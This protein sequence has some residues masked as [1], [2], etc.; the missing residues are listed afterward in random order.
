MDT[1]EAM[2]SASGKLHALCTNTAKHI[3]HAGDGKGGMEGG[4]A[5][6]KASC[7]SI[8]LEKHVLIPTLMT[9]LLPSTSKG[10][11]SHL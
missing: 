4:E 10:L 11:G 5:F 9:P 1:Q 7:K 3:P 8:I 6:P 2:F